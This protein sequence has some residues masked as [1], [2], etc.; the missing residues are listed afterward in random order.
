MPE[1]CRFLVELLGRALDQSTRD[2]TKKKKAHVHTCH[3]TQDN[4]FIWTPKVHYPLHRS[5]PSVHIRH[6]AQPPPSPCTVCAC[7]FTCTLRPT[8]IKRPEISYVPLRKWRVVQF[9]SQ[10]ES[11]K[12][13]NI[14]A[15][16][17][18][19]CLSFITL[20]HAA[21]VLTKDTNTF[22]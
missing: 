12:F 15:F 7:V 21:C 17:A 10:F 19:L 3:Q 9:P 2:E 16:V 5:Q 11:F 13:P 20:S 6:Q 8:K 22:A 14:C 18:F 4:L 1:C